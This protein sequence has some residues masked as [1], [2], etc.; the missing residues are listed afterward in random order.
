MSNTKPIWK[1]VLYER[2]P[3]P[4]N[5]TDKKIFLRDLRKNINVRELTFTEAVLGSLLILQEFCNIV[6]FVSIY[7]YLLYEWIEPVVLL[8][9]MSVVTIIAFIYYILVFSK[10][11]IHKLGND[12]RT[13]ITFIVVGRL[14]SPVLHTLTDTVSTDTIYTTTFLMMAIH[15]IF[16]DYGVGAA[17]VSN[18]VSLSTAIFASICL[19]SRLSTAF[20]AFI[21]MTAA[22]EMFVLF[23]ILCTALKNPL[24]FVWILL[25][26]DIYLLVYLS[27]LALILYMSTVVLI[28]IV[29]PFLFVYLQKH[30]ETIYGPWDE[31]VVDD[32]DSIINNFQIL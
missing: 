26:I 30:K 28:S 14:F 16:Y 15:M 10:N 12:L 5:Y 23:P 24:Y 11:V 13:I 27:K 7:F 17:I 6:T 3:Y 20:N 1:K 29:C 19:A 4:D 2:Q 22:I 21:L 18:S 8:T 32:V 25:I 9:C 31:A